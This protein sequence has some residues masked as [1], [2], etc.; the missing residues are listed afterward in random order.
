MLICKSR[1]RQLTLR[2]A[3]MKPLFSAFGESVTAFEKFSNEFPNPPYAEKSAAILVE[4]Y[5]NTVVM[6]QPLEIHRPDMAKAQMEAKQ[7]YLFQLGFTVLRQCQLWTSLEI[8]ESI[9]SYRTIQPSDESRRVLLVRRIYY[10]PQPYYDGSRTWLQCIHRKDYSQASHYFQKYIRLEK[11]ENTTALADAYNR[12]GDCYLHVRNFEEA[13]HYYSQA[14]QMNTPSGDYSFY[15]LALVSGLQKD[16]SGKITLLNRLIGKYPV[17]I[18]VNAIYE[19]DRRMEG[20][21]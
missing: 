19:K 16:Y 3:C 17:S 13:K 18:A 5:M 9:H 12:V 1:N 2:L 20:Q 14:E 4:A 7:K 15:Q 10:H 6:M 11:G 21:Q 8:P